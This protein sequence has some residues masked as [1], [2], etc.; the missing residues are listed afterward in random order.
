MLVF[1]LP[2]PKSSVLTTHREQVERGSEAGLVVLGG[3]QKQ[4]REL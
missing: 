4:A 1:P 3:E 2:G